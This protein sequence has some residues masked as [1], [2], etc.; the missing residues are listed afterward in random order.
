MRF[1][2]SEHV[3]SPAFERP[4]LIV[5]PPQPLCRLG[6]PSLDEN[7]PLPTC[8]PET[9]GMFLEVWQLRR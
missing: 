6:P 3:M 1:V 9:P 8:E 5:L 2:D 7:S 4:A